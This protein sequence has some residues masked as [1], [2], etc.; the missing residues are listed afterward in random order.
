MK[1]TFIQVT[2]LFIC[3]FSFG[4]VLN[5]TIGKYDAIKIAEQFV[6][7]NGYCSLPPNRSNLSYELWDNYRGNDDS[8]LK[9]RKNT[10]KCNASYIS[11]E[12][13][14]WHIGFL[15]SKIQAIHSDTSN[16]PGRSI[17]ISKDGKE[18]RMAHKAP[19]FSKFRKL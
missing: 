13:K 1:R 19:L 9:R 14:E 10:L 17:I 2:L 16:A 4:Q 7:D 6:K 18:V 12:A 5:D 3:N 11:E 8:I 15:S